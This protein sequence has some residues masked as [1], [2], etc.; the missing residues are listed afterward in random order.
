MGRRSDH[1]REELR[2]LAL[3]AA[4][5]VVERDGLRELSARQVARKIGYAVGTLYNLF[6]DFDDLVIQV[7]ARTLDALH[8]DLTQELERARGQGAVLALALRYS[9][10]V[11]NHSKR[12]NALF[13]HSLPAGRE[14]PPW[15][16]E[17]IQRLLGILAAALAP[18]FPSGREAQR[19]QAAQLL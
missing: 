18:Y 16:Q 8:Q 15:Y 14:L 1:S 7:N 17:K 4:E 19:D 11:V 2:E 12:W 10:F 9:I 6:E 3:R 5:K 13:E